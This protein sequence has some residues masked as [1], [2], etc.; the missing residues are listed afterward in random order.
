[1]DDA[2]GNG[3]RTSDQ[4]GSDDWGYNAVVGLVLSTAS[5]PAAY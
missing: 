4:A 5:S 2:H 3:K 1:M